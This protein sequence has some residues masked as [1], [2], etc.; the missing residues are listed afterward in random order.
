M[1]PLVGADRWPGRAAARGRSPTDLAASCDRLQSCDRTRRKLEGRGQFF[2]IIFLCVVMETVEA[3]FDDVKLN[4]PQR[5]LRAWGI[6]FMGVIALVPFRLPLFGICFQKFQCL[7]RVALHR[8]AA[9]GQCDLH[10][11]GWLPVAIP[12]AIFSEGAIHDNDHHLAHEVRI[13]IALNLISDAALGDNILEGS[14]QAKVVCQTTVEQMQVGV[15]CGILIRLQF[16]RFTVRR[17]RPWRL[18]RAESIHAGST[19]PQLPP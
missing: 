14:T 1:F 15:L 3:D 18:V 6:W 13:E 19:H 8:H 4:A 5:P 2:E 10:N 17:V 9:Q 7:E 11:V 12:S 16:H